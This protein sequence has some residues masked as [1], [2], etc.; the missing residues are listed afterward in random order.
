LR[1]YNSIELIVLALAGIPSHV[2]L[3]VPFKQWL[4]WHFATQN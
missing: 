2:M 3:S 4:P 1:E